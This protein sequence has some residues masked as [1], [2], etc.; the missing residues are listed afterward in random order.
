MKKK[1]KRKKKKENFTQLCEQIEFT[2]GNK[3]V[4]WNNNKSALIKH[5]RDSS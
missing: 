5:F 4:F 3:A 2:L 1:K